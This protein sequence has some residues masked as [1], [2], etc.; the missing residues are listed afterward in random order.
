MVG[1]EGLEAMEPGEPV[2]REEPGAVVGEDTS[3]FMICDDLPTL[4]G[5]LTQKIFSGVWRWTARGVLW[6]D[7]GDI[8]TQG[9]TG[10]SLRM[11][12]ESTGFHFSWSTI[13]VG[14]RLIHD[15]LGLS[16]F[17]MGKLKERLK[18]EEA[19]LS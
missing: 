2:H 11:A 6:T 18:T 19:A 17:L 15:S 10:S 3:T 13:V 7:M 14:R 4:V 9:R 1:K 5:F 12:G 16:P 8:K